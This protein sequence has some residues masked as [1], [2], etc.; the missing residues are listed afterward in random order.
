M[1]SLNWWCQLLW[2]RNLV[3]WYLKCWWNLQSLS[4]EGRNY[5]H[6]NLRLRCCWW[7]DIFIY[8]KNH[9]VSETSDY[10]MNQ[11][12]L[13]PSSTV[14]VI[15]REHHLNSALNH[16][17]SKMIT[18]HHK[19]DQSK[20]HL[21]EEL[22]YMKAPI[23]MERRSPILK[24]NHAFKV[25]ISHWS[26][27]ADTSKVDGSKYNEIEIK[28]NNYKKTIILIIFIKKLLKWRTLVQCKAQSI[29][30]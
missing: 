2:L 12:K 25:S 6:L 23:I 30:E 18:S 27:W 13:V 10:G 28:I 8:F 22:P 19:S 20:Y 5:F 3:R 7:Y 4:F 16:Q 1:E 26:K 9:G 29:K 17:T 15:S 14:N 11:K 24:I 21:K